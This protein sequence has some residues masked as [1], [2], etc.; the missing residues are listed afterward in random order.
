MSPNSSDMSS[1]QNFTSVFPAVT[2]PGPSAPPR[3]WTTHSNL[4]FACLAHWATLMTTLFCIYSA[5]VVRHLKSCQHCT[6][7]TYLCQL[8][9][10]VLPTGDGREA[11]HLCFAERSSPAHHELYKPHLP[12]FTAASKP[13]HICRSANRVNSWGQSSLELSIESCQWIF[14][15]D[16]WI[17]NS[18]FGFHICCLQL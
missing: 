8:C 10:V 2:L 6:C 12:T 18:S 17:I 1:S 16:T 3:N 14:Y 13:N 4:H 5:S 15:E 7:K 11:Q 9:I